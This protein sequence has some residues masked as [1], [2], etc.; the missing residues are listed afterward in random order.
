[1]L[2]RIGYVRWCGVRR[3]LF[4]ATLAGSLPDDR[5]VVLIPLQLLIALHPPTLVLRDNMLRISV[6]TF[7]RL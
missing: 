2:C 5:L 6:V 1:M 7:L 3:W 4:S